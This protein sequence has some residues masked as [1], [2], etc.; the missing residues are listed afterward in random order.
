V[1]LAHDGVTGRL[2]VY[3]YRKLVGFFGQP[4]LSGIPQQ[5]PSLFQLSEGGSQFSVFVI[6][7]DLLSPLLVVRLHLAV[8]TPVCK[9]PRCGWVGRANQFGSSPKLPH[10]QQRDFG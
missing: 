1:R 8:A 7:L 4:L 6:A 5:L 10:A 3:N 9:P 2:W